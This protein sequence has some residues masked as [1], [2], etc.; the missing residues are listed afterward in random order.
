MAPRA[1]LA[2]SA[3]EHSRWIGGRCGPRQSN[4]RLRLLCFPYAGGGVSVFRAWEDELPE[5][6]DVCPVRLPGRESR[7][8]EPPFTRLTPLVETLAR[9]LRPMLD[10]PF[11]FFGHSMGAFVSFELARQ[12]RRE[13]GPT[14]VKMFVSGASAP[15]IPDPDPP[16]HELPDPEFLEELQRLNGMPKEVIRVEEV[17]RLMMPTLRAD[18]GLVETYTYSSEEPLGC[19]IS[20]Y[21]GKKD[22]KATPHDLVAWSEQTASDFRLRLF[23]GDHFFLLGA[24]ESV[25]DDVSRELSE[26]VSRREGDL[27]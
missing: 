8:K 17:L 6:V 12:L 18:V 1:A 4:A 20:S 26:I 27:R 7:W 9:V 24:R 19:P 23:P 10:V 22:C 15:Q 16:I 3:S 14:P 5:T 2:K 25:L 11:A 21:G 13:G